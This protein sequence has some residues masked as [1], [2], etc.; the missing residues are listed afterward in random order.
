[1][2]FAVMSPQISS[3]AP[4]SGCQSAAFISRRKKVVGAVCY[5]D[6]PDG[7]CSTFG[8]LKMIGLLKMAADVAWPE[9]VS[10]MISSVACWKSTGIIGP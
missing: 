10:P 1:M 4:L 6:L 3:Q 2:N 9:E 8:T 5:L 7:D